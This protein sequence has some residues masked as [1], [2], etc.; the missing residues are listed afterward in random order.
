[1]NKILASLVLGVVLAPIANAGT[2]T[3][4][5]NDLAGFNA[6]IGS[7]SVTLETFG[8]TAHFPITTGVLN[9]ATSGVA[10]IT[11]G[12]IQPGV[13]YS[14]TIGSGNFFNIDCC[15]NNST[16]FLDTVTGAGPLTVTFDHATNAFGF[17]QQS[18]MGNLLHIA[19]DFTS[20][21][22]YVNDIALPGAN[23]FI[24]FISNAGDIVSAKISGSNIVFSFAIDDFRFVTSPVSPSQVPEPMSLALV[25]LGL[26]GIANSLRKKR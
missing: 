25:G 7:A 14:T 1:M 11:A 15:S 21:A 24:G 18:F 19:I 13:T 6:A 22:Q 5:A 17:V 26:A 8:S 4:Y 10:G 16:P 20:G 2:I 23:E 9:S 3:T 12:L